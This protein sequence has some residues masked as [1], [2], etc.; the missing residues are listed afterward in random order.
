MGI[1]LNG[2]K[3]NSLEVETY[4]CKRQVAT[5]TADECNRYE[6]Q[7]NR[8]YSMGN[9]LASQLATISFVGGSFP[10]P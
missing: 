3:I 10:I 7:N 2:E 5:M 8:T 4:G 9:L 6:M 1:T